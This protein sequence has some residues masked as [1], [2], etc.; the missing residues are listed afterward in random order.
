HIDTSP[1][2]PIPREALDTLAATLSSR[3]RGKGLLWGWTVVRAVEGRRYVVRSDG[4]RIREPHRYVAVFSYASV[5]CKRGVKIEDQRQW[6]AARLEDLPSVQ[7]MAD[8]TEAMGL[9]L[10]ARRWARKVPYYQ[11][12]VVFEGDAAAQLF[13]QLLPASLEGTPPPP[14]SGKSFET[15]TLAGPRL[16]RRVL[17]RGWHVDDDPASTPPGFAGRFLYDEDGVPAEPVE[18]VRNGLVVDMVM[19]RAPRRDVTWTNGRAREG[20]GRLT[21]WRVTAPAGL[22]D[23]GFDRHVDQ[24]RRDNDVHRVLVVRQL[25]TVD[26]RGGMTPTDAV[27]RFP[28]GRETPVL[29]LEF[30]GVDRRTLH[31]I[32][33]VTRR[34]QVKGYLGA[35]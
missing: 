5:V 1:V 7:E 29:A 14:E 25:D 28:D 23:H 3:L 13:I 22:T 4:T 11:G 32:A 26:E 30:Q 27:W 16:K 2:E 35:M 19:S 6:V 20:T 24:L 21:S 18:L 33:G 10:Q 12:P 8:E 31:A 9:V 34:V 17:P 15:L